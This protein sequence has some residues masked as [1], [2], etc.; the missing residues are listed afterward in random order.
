[1]LAAL[2]ILIY[3]I[4]AIFNYDRHCVSFE[5]PRVCSLGEYMGGVLALMPLAIP[6]LAIQYWWISLPLLILFP[7]MGFKIS[8]PNKIFR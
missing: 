4:A 7:L 3:L 8:M 2:V 6:M 1:M 5:M